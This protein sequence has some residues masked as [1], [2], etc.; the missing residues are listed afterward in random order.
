MKTMLSTLASFTSMLVLLLASFAGPVAAAPVPEQPARLTSDGPATD[1]LPAWARLPG[2]GDGQSAPPLAEIEPQ[3]LHELAADDKADFFIWMEEKADLSPAYELETKEERGRFVYETLRATAERTQKALRAHLDRQGVDYRPFYVANKILVRGGQRALLMDVASRPEVARISANHHYQLEEPVVAPQRPKQ[4]AAAEPNIAFVNAD[5][6]WAMGHTGQGTVLAGNDT[7]VDW[8]HPALIDQYRGWD[9]VAADH[10][11]NWWD[12]TG[13]YPDAPSDGDGHGTHTSGTIVGDDGRGNQIG[14]APRARLIHCKNLDDSGSGSDAAATECFEWDLAPWDLDGRNPRPD[15]APD[16]VNISWGYGAGGSSVF[17]DEIAALRAAGIIVVVSAGNAGPGC[18]TLGSP[19]DDEQSLTTGSVGGT[20]GSLPGTLSSFSSR[21]PSALYPGAYIPDVVAPG[22]SIRSS[23]PGGGYEGGWSGTSMAAPHVTGLI[24]LLWS[25]NPS[26]RGM[27]NETVEIIQ[28]TAVPLTGQ[29]GSGCGGDYVTGPNH[30]WGHGTIDGL[31]AVEAALRFG[32]TGRLVGTVTDGVDPVA[33]ATIEATLT[34]TM[35]WHTSSDVLGEYAMTIISG[36]YTVD[37]YAFGYLPAQFGHVS[38]ISG[39]TTTLDIA[40]TA[41]DV[42]VL[43]GTVTAAAT[44]WPLY[45]SIDIAGYPGDPI[46]TDP[47]TGRYAITLPEGISYALTVEAWVDGY[48]PARGDVGLLTED[49]VHD[50]ALQADPGACA[51]P[52]YQLNRTLLLAE[53]FDAGIPGSWTVV[54]NVGNGCVWRD[55]DPGARGNM[56]GG[57][58]PFAVAD[59]DRCDPMDT[60]LRTPAFDA[61]GYTGLQIAYKNDYYDLGST[62]QVDVFDGGTWSTVEDLSGSSSRG[63]ET[64]VVKTTAGAGSA[65]AQV[66]WHYVAGWDWWWEVDEVRIYG[67]TCTLQPGGLVVGNVY[68]ERTGEPLPGARVCNEDGYVT[69]AEATP[70]DAGVDDSFYTAFSPQGTKTFTGT[71]TSYGADV[72]PVNVV[73]GAAIWHDFELPAGWLSPD[74]PALEASLFM[75]ETTTLPLTVSNLGGV[76]VAFA[77]TETDRGVE[78]LHLPGVAIPGYQAPDPATAE[79]DPTYAG[80]HQVSRESWSYRPSADGYVRSLSVEVLLVA[81]GGA[82]QLEAMLEAYPDIDAVD[83]F[84]ARVATPNLDQLLAYDTVVVM[85]DAPFANPAALGNALADY[86]DGGGTVVQAVPTF[87]DLGEGWALRGRFVDEGYS[88]LIGTGDW[89]SWADLGSFDA[90]HPIM[91][92]V[93]DAGD[94][95]RQVVDLAAGADVV[96]EWTDDEFVATKGSVVAVNAFLGDGFSWSGDV[97]LIVH[98][99]ITWLQAPGGMDWLAQDPVS[100]TVDA[101]DEQVVTVAFDGGAESVEQPGRYHGSLRLNNDSPYDPPTV[102]VTMTVNAPPT[103]GRL[104]GTVTGLGYCDADPAPLEGARV[105]IESWMMET[106]TVT[107]P[108][109]ISFESFEADDGGYVS[110]GATSWAWG[111]PTSGPGAAHSGAKLWAT[112]LF[113]NYDNDEDGAIESPDIDLSAYAGQSL[114]LSWWQYYNG[115][116]CCDHISVEIS[117]DGG[118]T[119]SAPVYGPF[120]GGEVNEQVWERQTVTLVPAYNVHNFRLRFR[121]TSDYSVT[122]PGWYVDD[123]AI[124]GEEEPTEVDV[125]VSWRL[126]TNGDGYFERWLDEAHSPLTVTVTTPEYEIGQVAGVEVEGQATTN[127]DFDLR[128][129]QPCAQVAPP[130][131]SA[132]LDMGVSTT[133]PVSITNDGAV[134]L[135][136]GLRMRDRGFDIAA[137]PEGT[138]TWLTRDS[139]GMGVAASDSGATV[140]YPASYRYT[141]ATP[142]PAAVNILVYTDDWIHPAPNTLVQQA[143]TRLGLPATVHVDGDYAG[144]EAHLT[145]GGPWDLVIWSGENSTAPDTTL[146]A[147][148]AYLQD[149]GRLAA[150]YW[151][152]VD[153]PTDPLWAEMGFAFADNYVIPPPAH[154]WEPGHGVFTYPENAPAWI[155]RVQNSTK[156]QGTKLAP[157]ADGVAV[158]GTTTTPAPNEAAIVIRD[159]SQAVYKGLRDV[160]TQ[161]DDDGDGV[162]DGVELWENIIIGLLHGFG[163]GP[164]WLA[165][166][167][168]SGTVPADGGLVPVEV[169][170]DAARLVQPGAYYATLDVRSNDPVNNAIGMPVTM[171]V[172]APATWGKLEGT[173]QSLGHCDANP[174]PLGEAEVLIENGAAV[175]VTTEVSGTY[176]AWVEQGTYQVAVS[177]DGHAGQAATVTVTAGATT[178]Q[179]FE[180]RWLQPCVNVTPPELSAT[181]DMGMST[182]LSL[183]IGNSGAAA[184]TFELSNADRGGT[185]VGTT[186]GG[187]DPFGYT[188]MDSTD[189]G[190]PRYDF[191][192][193]STT[194]DPVYLGDDDWAGPFELGFALDFYGTEW[195]QYYVSSNGYLSFGGGWSDFGNDCPLPSGNTPDN[196]IAVHWDDLNP[197]A[198]GA[199]YRQSFADCPR[200]SGA[201]EVVLFDQVPHYGGDSSGLFEV[202]IFENGSMLMQFQDPGAEAGSGATTGIE[203]GDGTVGLTYEACNTAYLSP[204]LAVCFAYP[205]NAP[206]CSTG[207]VGWLSEDPATGT[208]PADG[209]STPVDV[210]LDAARVEHPG[211]Y[212]ATLRVESDDPVNSRIGVPVTMTVNPSPAWGMLEGS[213]TGLGYCD[214][215]PAPL[216]GAEVLVESWMTETITVT[217]PITVLF[218]DFEADDGGYVSTGTTSFAW[219]APTSGPTAAHSGAKLWATNLSDY[220]DNNEDGAIESP[221]ID[222]SAHAGQSLELSWWQYY[223]GENCCD[224]VSVE[225]SDDGGQTWS[226][227]VYGPFDGGDLAEQVWEQQTVTLGPAYMVQDF[228][229]RFRFTSDYSLTYPGWYIDDVAITG[230]EQA[231]FDVPVSWDLETNADGHFVRWMDEAHSPLT[232]TVSYPEYEIG[233]V[234]GVE[235]EGQATASEDFDLRWLQPCITVSPAAIQAALMPGESTTVPLILRNDGA[236]PSDFE[237]HERTFGLASRPPAPQA[238]GHVTVVDEEKRKPAAGA[239]VGPADS[240]G[241][242]PF[243]YTFVDSRGSSDLA[244]DWIEIAPPAGGSGTAVGLSGVDDGHV[245]PIGTSFPFAFYG[246]AYTDL[247]F[248]SNGTIYFEDDYLG[249]SNGPIPGYSGYGVNTFIAHFW[250]DL[251]V[252]GEVYYQDF[253]DLLVVEYYDV[254]LFGGADLGTWEVILYDNGNVLMQYLD[255]AIS[256]GSGATFGIQGDEVTGLQYAYNAPAVTDGLAVCF[257]YP[258][259]PLCGESDDVPWLSTEPLTGTVGADSSFAVDVTLDTMTY[260]LGAYATTL[261]IDTDDPFHDA[262]SVPVTM[263]VGLGPTCGFET[264]SPDRLG[265]TTVFTNTTTGVEP[266]SYAWDFGDGGASTAENPTHMYAHVGTYAVVLTATDAVGTSVCRGTVSIEGVEAGFVSNSPVHIGEPMVFTN[267]TRAIPAA[268]SYLW[269]FGDGAS[270]TDENPVHTYGAVGAYTVTLSASNASGGSTGSSDVYQDTVHVIAPAVYLPLA[271][272]GR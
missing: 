195:S 49:E 117:D 254:S 255:S 125:P 229:L 250:D 78:P 133:L 120:D 85:S 79:A 266:V 160:S 190:G 68:D 158:A 113:G 134:E 63:P 242:D 9:G 7:G 83:T 103:W 98:N 259:A 36:T 176:T 261:A 193:I 104:E 166:D 187:P 219:G 167:P 21:G 169:T 207:D 64:R 84:D 263:T 138:I 30:D 11:Y 246:A 97:D 76:P 260:T 153:I 86:V 272:R 47:L 60:I 107:N 14:M 248:A 197:G 87:Y 233:Q 66:G 154:W 163:G 42:H 71:M 199:I 257:I 52:G 16:A 141:P 89:F 171:T 236:A 135:S 211:E 137:V 183:N 100:G 240:G 258:G 15:L 55:D 91:Q 227:P 155:N 268:T 23:V 73:E 53:D 237:L 3:V 92:G 140:A 51:A 136:F 40:L 33:D 170:L 189:A 265:E 27:V 232:V 4:T 173:V 249:F 88:P 28:E 56:T 24:G 228:R 146:D 180:L 196:I 26:L 34:P 111:A 270:S 119:W 8:D 116:N 152:Q 43:S 127:Q 121:F 149:G 225:I 151:R 1:L 102:P 54:D 241:P 218:E 252:D 109:T 124:V 82:G 239:G 223:D 221:T 13:S 247:A 106:I 17:E 217:N 210:T 220:Y 168:V 177:A 129:L 130:A 37:A 202:I 230:H 208:V 251:V 128:W 65:N 101:G 32:G 122:Y 6:V 174:A 94:L 256:D 157:L 108:I 10:N 156:S 12:A 118:Q 44:G 243:G 31:A 59:S 132:A 224:Y 126:E 150:T 147:L 77:F 226:A 184:A 175:S 143:I 235:V 123:V 200:A 194:G 74:P 69:T 39:T 234:A 213:V 244:F 212:Y 204:E 72:D 231:R 203:N 253:G 18:A 19:G 271:L 178:S 114:E 105:L 191:L 58:G 38:V 25:A 142:S 222:L 57:S 165:A 139:E 192:D 159:D 205:G 29:A 5:Q 264:S 145:T 185:M 95:L 209:G 179:D 181:L 215:D 67:T 22:E 186:A 201:C 206:D 182:T 41:A 164:P 238:T 62:A 188:T 144:F 214:A 80:E 46:W 35:T 245:F 45:A 50:F 93:T 172:A 96:A 61:T 198:G 115:E 2:T 161:A 269:T 75:G 148:L 131:I 90:A 267:T 48:Q 81:A 262:V 70:D 216:E 110:T 162:L 112:D 20:A 99:S